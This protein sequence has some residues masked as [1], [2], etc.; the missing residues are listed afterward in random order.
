MTSPGIGNPR[1]GRPGCPLC[2]SPRDTFLLA[3]VWTW[4][5]DAKQLWATDTPGLVI[6]QEPITRSQGS[7]QTHMCRF[8]HVWPHADQVAVVRLLGTTAAGKTM[9][10]R[11]MISQNVARLE[12]ASEDPVT[13]L[14]ASR[15]CQR[16]PAP[17]RRPPSRC[18]SW[19]R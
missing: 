4:G 16:W 15:I 7:I 1:G 8:G 17:M 5:G 14:E 9:L 19:A 13:I 3:E 12:A 11:N 10:L 2:G 18:R 6:G